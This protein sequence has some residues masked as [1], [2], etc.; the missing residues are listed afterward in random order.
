M[1]AESCGGPEASDR[2]IIIGCSI[3]IWLILT[4]ISFLYFDPGIVSTLSCIIFCLGGI[5]FNRIR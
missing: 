4:I 5:F 3:I 2:S 1:S